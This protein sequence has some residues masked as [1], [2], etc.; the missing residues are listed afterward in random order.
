[1]AKVPIRAPAHLAP[2]L[3]QF[4]SV[5]ARLPLD[6]ALSAVYTI[7][8]IDLSTDQDALMAASFILT[9]MKD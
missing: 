7:L 1:M 3:V 5:L 9:I 4:S 2:E 8:H 6:N